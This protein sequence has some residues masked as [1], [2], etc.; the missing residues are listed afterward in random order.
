M[1]IYNNH[2]CHAGFY[3]VTLHTTQKIK[4][5]KMKKWYL[6]K[7]CSDHFLMPQCTRIDMSDT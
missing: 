1:W 7:L 5:V 4:E 3:S 6:K 2:N